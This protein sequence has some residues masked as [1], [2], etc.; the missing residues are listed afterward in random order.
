[1]LYFYQLGEKVIQ[2]FQAIAHF[3]TIPMN[4]S[5]FIN[6]IF[7]TT[8]NKVIDTLLTPGRE[9]VRAILSIGGSLTFL[10]FFMSVGIGLFFVITIIKWVLPTS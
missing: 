7:G 4:S 10:E 3:F 9:L 8:G 6:L 5:E 2:W 1:M